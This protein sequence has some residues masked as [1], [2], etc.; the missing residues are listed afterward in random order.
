M[1]RSLHV[2]FMLFPQVLSLDFI[3]PYSVLRSGPNVQ[4]DLIWKNTEPIMSSDRLLLSPT[5]AIANCPQ[6]DVLCVPGGE[7][8]LEMMEDQDI[9]NFIR[10]QSTGLHYLCSVCTGSL[11]LGAAGLLLGKKATTHWQSFD[12]LTEFGAIAVHKRVVSDHCLFTAAG[13]TSGID[14]ALHLAGKLWG[15]E[16][17]QTIQLNMEYHPEPPY[18][19]G[20]PQSA[21]SSC[22]EA[23]RKKSEERQAKRLLVARRAAAKLV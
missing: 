17:A 18:N 22:V 3:G 19:S 10:A 14:M 15:D 11:I 1:T 5:L 16:I 21:P 4:T 7:G 20:T 23:Q 6:L 13:V 8:I 9:L 2:G 12:M